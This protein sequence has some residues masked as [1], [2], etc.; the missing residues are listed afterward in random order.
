MAKEYDP[1]LFLGQISQYGYFSEE[2]PACF[3]SESYSTKI[4]EAVAKVQE[5]L[6][7][8]RPACV[9]IRKGEN[10]RRVIS[11][12]NP[13]S[14]S[15]TIKLMCDNWD[16]LIEFSKSDESQ[17]GICSIDSY[18]KHINSDNL[19]EDK[20]KHSKY[21][22]NVKDRIGAS[23]GLRY[24]LELD[25]ESCYDSIYTHSIT[26]AICGKA[27]AK[28]MHAE[29]SPKSTDYTLGD[30]LDTAIRAMN[31]NMTHGII[32]GPFTSRIFSEILLARIDSEIKQKLGE[33]KIATEF[34]RYVDD[35]CFYFGSVDDRRRALHGIDSVLRE[36][37]LRINQSKIKEI[38]FPFD[39][40]IPLARNLEVAYNAEGDGFFNVL[41]EAGLLYQKGEQGA[42]RYAL[43]Y[44]QDKKLDEDMQSEC[45]N[46]I[47]S[48]L[49]NL[50][51]D[52][53]RF[54]KYVIKIIK[55]NEEHFEKKM[56]R[57]R[58]NEVLKTAMRDGHDQE[59]INILYLLRELEL[60][61]DALNVLSAIESG[62]DFAALIAL[63]LLKNAR[64]RVADLERY[65][66]S[67]DA[68]IA[69]LKKLMDEESMLGS[70]WLLKYECKAHDLADIGFESGGENSFFSAIYKMKISFYK[71]L[72]KPTFPRKGS[73]KR[74]EVHS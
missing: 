65:E 53:P 47:A 72:K 45:A 52:D 9:S 63:D 51:V 14:F 36:F 25:I 42:Y 5:G 55:N 34:R 20:E 70:H 56:I 39:V 40:L 44:I 1:E 38:D 31:D 32:T 59:A 60:D 61:V 3:S 29:R 33:M 74:A 24:K 13:I 4:K 35:Y 15:Q 10:S 68:E 26:W 46:A 41:N 48:I 57:D 66:A 27:Q 73:R 8:S 28:K 2:L 12:P 67:I 50:T 6:V 49:I 64:T 22:E 21:V 16:K 71:G 58:L 11:I 18:G 43:K 17:S 23:F 7:V 37:D 69:D 30:K 62:N 19:I 54:N